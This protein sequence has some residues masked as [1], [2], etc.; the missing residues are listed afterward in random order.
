MDRHK[1][2]PQGFLHGEGFDISHHWNDQLVKQKQFS[3]CS[4]MPTF[5][6]VG[7]ERFQEQETLEDYFMEYE[8]Q[9]QRFKDHMSFQ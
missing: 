8:C 9:S 4:T 2:S 5:L 7:N 3:Q 6:A 1:E